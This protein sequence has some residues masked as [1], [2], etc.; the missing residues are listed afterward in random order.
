MLRNI[1]AVV[2]GTEPVTV[3][4]ATR[5]FL[6]VDQVSVDDRSEG[7]LTRRFHVELP[8]EWSWSGQ[9]SAVALGLAVRVGVELVVTYRRPKSSLALL[10]II[11]EDVRAIQA[12]LVSSTTMAPETTGVY[13]VDAGQYDFDPGER[14]GDMAVLT[15]PLTITYDP[16]ST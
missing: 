11:L 9:Q 4:D 15:I 7:G 1:V 10:A 14:T 8:G 6:F 16:E 13:Q 2:E 12:R 5:A 3:T